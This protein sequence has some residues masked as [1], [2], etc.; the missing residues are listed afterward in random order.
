MSR[1]RSGTVE[2]ESID[3]LPGNQENIPG[4]WIMR[5]ENSAGEEDS[6]F[7]CV[8]WLEKHELDL[9]FTNSTKPDP[10]PCTL[11]Q[12]RVDDRYTWVESIFPYTRCYYTV[13]RSSNNH[14]RKCCYFINANKLGALI[15]GPRRGGTID[16]FHKLV[17]ELKDDHTESD[18]LGF[19][20]CC[21]G[22]IKRARL[23]K[24][25]YQLRPS[26]GCEAYVP[27]VQGRI[28]LRVCV[29]LIY[30]WPLNCKRFN[31]LPHFWQQE[32]SRTLK[33]RQ[34]WD[35]EAEYV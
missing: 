18:V 11:D 5:L 14:G 29:L 17:P 3:N 16:R 19:Q 27:P 4:R 34:L 6:D 13:R 12:A 33:N 15:I 21:I 9:D 24:L 2:A 10:C 22:A 32:K 31:F 20:Y 23:C 28:F 25:Y 26:E 30:F 35:D 1:N 7:N 8:V